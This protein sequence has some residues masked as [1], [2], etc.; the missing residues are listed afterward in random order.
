MTALQSS[1]KEK[2]NKERRI[3]KGKEERILKE[4]EQEEGLSPRGGRATRQP[5][6]LDL[7][8]VRY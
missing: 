4:K 8:P 5:P 7:Q 2:E 6:K 3:L 1:G